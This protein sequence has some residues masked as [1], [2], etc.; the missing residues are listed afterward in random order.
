MCTTLEDDAPGLM[1]II[2]TLG[3]LGM[4]PHY[5]KCFNARPVFLS[6]D[7]CIEAHSTTCFSINGPL[8]IFGK[9]FSWK[10]PLQYE[11]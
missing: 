1:I 5:E 11:F 2:Q 8:Y 7:D 4:F 6:H 9:G 3:S 10:V